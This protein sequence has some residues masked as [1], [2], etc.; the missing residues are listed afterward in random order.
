MNPR[1]LLRSFWF[2]L[3]SEKKYW[4]LPLA[5]GFFMLLLLILL[6]ES[7]PL[8]SPFLYTIF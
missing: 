6:S 8:L 2:F 5:A 4:A 7:A 3:K 1:L